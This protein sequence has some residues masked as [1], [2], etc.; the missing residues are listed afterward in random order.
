MVQT[1]WNGVVVSNVG[2]TILFFTFLKS[3]H[4]RIPPLLLGTNTIGC[5]HAVG[6]VSFSMMLCSSRVSSSSFTWGIRGTATGRD[7]LMATEMAPSFNTKW[8]G[9]PFIGRHS[10]LKFVGKLGI[11]CF[12]SASF[13]SGVIISLVIDF[14]EWLSLSIARRCGNAFL[15]ASLS[16]FTFSCGYPTGSIPSR[17]WAF[18]DKMFCLRPCK[19]WNFVETR[20]FAHVISAS[21]WR[22]KLCL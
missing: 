16:C 17:I 18:F 7:P 2:L 10:P 21:T 3:T 6:F 8:H 5:T 20:L 13:F 12:L 22:V 14:S 9:R 15:P 4:K 11:I 1:A 19:T